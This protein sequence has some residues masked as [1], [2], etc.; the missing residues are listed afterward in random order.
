MAATETRLFNICDNSM[1]Q[2]DR[3][4]SFFALYFFHTS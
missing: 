3:E 4:L 2:K 1:L